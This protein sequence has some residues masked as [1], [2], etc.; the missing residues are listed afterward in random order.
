MRH[1]TALLYH[2]CAVASR[3]IRFASCGTSGKLALWTRYV[4]LNLMQCS[5]LHSKGEQFNEFSSDKADFP[6]RMLAQEFVSFGFHICFYY[7]PV[8]EYMFDFTGSCATVVNIHVLF[9]SILVCHMWLIYLGLVS[10]VINSALGRRNANCQIWLCQL[11]MSVLLSKE[12][13][14]EILCYSC[15]FFQIK[16]WSSK[17]PAVNFFTRQTLYH[18]GSELMKLYVNSPN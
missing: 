2:V 6:A 10:P 9:S 4:Y 11:S 17:G 16:L 14:C 1:A 13:M 5:V 3:N 7:I 18:R 15:F 12:W 8:M